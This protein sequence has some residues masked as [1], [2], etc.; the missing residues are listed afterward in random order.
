LKIFGTIKFAGLIASYPVVV[1]K[2]LAKDIES[3][4][5][6]YDHYLIVKKKECRGFYFDQRLYLCIID[7][8]VVDCHLF[9]QGLN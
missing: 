9:G 6:H 5:F 2:T 1:W 3:T 4:K 8:S 7:Q